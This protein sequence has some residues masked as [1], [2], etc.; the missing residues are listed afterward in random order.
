[1]CASRRR[2]F[3]LV[4]V[5]VLIVVIGIALAGVLLIFQNTVRGSADPQIRKQA[6]AI[7]EAMLD[8]I[9]LNPYGPLPGTGARANFDDV[10][11]YAGFNSNPPGGITDIQ[12]NPVAGLGAY[13]VLVTVTTDATTALNDSGATLAAVGESRRVTVTVSVTGHPEM[14]VSLDGYRLRYDGP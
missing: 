13:N 5:V 11:D 6:L 8:E 3:T 14:T 10:Q 2:G 9:L 7:A 1:M 12:G 4:E